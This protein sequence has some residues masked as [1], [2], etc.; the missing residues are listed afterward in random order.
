M[1]RQPL[2]LPP[3]P[4]SIT[5]RPLADG[6]VVLFMPALDEEAAVGDCIA[7]APA[8]VGGREVKVLV[9]DDGSTDDTAA[10]ARRAGA[11]VVSMPAPTGLGAAVRT[12]LAWAGEHGAAVVAFCDADG[13]YPPEELEALV[14]PVL[15]GEAD[16]VVGSRF[17][18][19]IDRMRPHRRAGNLILTRVLAWVAR[20][21]ISD[22]QSGF[23]ALSAEA[24]SAAEIIHDYNYAQVLTLDLLGKGFRYVEVPISYHF[25][26]TGDSFVKLGPYLWR[27]IPAVAAQLRGTARSDQGPGLKSRS[28]LRSSS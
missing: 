25:R 1:T 10:T 24:A 8:T 23:R 14:A 7:R 18:G 19:R 15:D 16:Y 26:T 5:T 3:S 9:V 27:V 12:G 22:G 20:R 11:A 21:P 4:P 13:E 2:R 17:A 6:P 28:I